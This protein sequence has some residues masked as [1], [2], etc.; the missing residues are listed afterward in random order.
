MRILRILAVAALAAVGL[1]TSAVAQDAAAKDTGSSCHGIQPMAEAVR[2][3]GVDK[4]QIDAE[5][6]RVEKIHLGTAKAPKVV[7][8]LCDWSI[9]TNKNQTESVQPYEGMAQRMLRIRRVS[10]TEEAAGT[11]NVKAGTYTEISI[12]RFAVKE[13]K[14]SVERIKILDWEKT[15]FEFVEIAT[16]NGLPEYDALYSVKVLVQEGEWGLIKLGDGI[17]V[18]LEPLGDPDGDTAKDK[19][20]AKNKAEA[21][22]TLVAHVWTPRSADPTATAE[23]E[24]APAPESSGKKVGVKAP[25][26]APK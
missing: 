18:Y 11:A 7:E 12:G 2:K 24:P 4:D 10:L 21:P 16:R 23:T 1:M 8:M 22:V 20:E 17:G 13:L 26:P 6:Y 9:F 25:T 19:A 5:R 14:L 3:D 15:G